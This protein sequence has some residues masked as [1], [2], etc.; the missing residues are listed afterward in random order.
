MNGLASALLIG[1]G[2]VVC[3]PES[4]LCG[5]LEVARRG[6]APDCPVVIPS[7]ATACQRKAAEEFVTWTEK[8]SGVRLPVV[9]DAEPLPAKAVVLGPTRYTQELLGG[10][11]AEAYP[12]SAF[13]LKLSG[14]RLVVAAASGHAVLYGV[15]EVLQRYGGVEF[16][17]P[18]IVTAPAG[19]LVVPAGLDEL[20]KPSVAVRDILCPTRFHDTAASVR[21]RYNG[22]HVAKTGNDRAEWGGEPC[23]L[24]WDADFCHCHSFHVI[25]S[26][27]EFG[28][29]HPEY[30]LK[31]SN[32]V[33]RVTGSKDPQLCL[34]NPDVIRLGRERLVNALRT[35]PRA[36]W[37]GISQ[38]D[39]TAWCQCADCRAID[40]REGG[41]SGSLC[42]YLNVMADEMA[43]VR[44]EARLTT[45]AYHQTRNPP[46]FLEL[47]KNVLV[48][49]CVTEC[50][51]SRPLVGHPNEGNR[52]FLDALQR[53]SRISG[54]VWIWDYCTDYEW[55]PAAM[56]D[57]GALA[58]NI[59][60][61]ADNKVQYVYESGDGCPYSFF[62]DLKAYVISRMLWNAHQPLEPLVGRFMK[63]CYGPAAEEA[64]AALDLFEKHDFDRT[65]LR[66][67]YAIDATKKEFFPTALFDRAAAHWRKAER[68]V[69]RKEPYA[70][71]V[72]RGRIG[73]DSVRLVRYCYDLACGDAPETDTP[74]YR[75]E[76]LAAAKEF[77]E[78]ENARVAAAKVGPDGKKKEP[79]YW[80]WAMDSRSCYRELIEAFL[81]GRPIPKRVR[82]EW[83]RR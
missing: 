32:G 16:F 81:A 23:S 25:A 35:R 17:T 47:R 18:D 29:T 11:T 63:A 42:E 30:F 20:V 5:G 66:M 76:M 73:N 34:T 24:N 80:G 21:F 77:M 44:P 70:E 52:T 8:I 64:R 40:D 57:I 61:F 62:F 9:T 83:V 4:A 82:G 15:Y 43:K 2:A 65:K 3:C 74:A 55:F 13:R 36:T 49:L 53:W 78:V 67:S 71:M 38:E 27:E 1:L 7:H 48:G 58:A 31:D 37:F 59:R 19:D 39:T 60:L 10:G 28:K 72:R 56:P 14:S 68:L 12:E 54:G 33:S 41:A 6:W 46:K 45:L 26:K 22:T 50:D 79:W 69:G 75:A 51:F